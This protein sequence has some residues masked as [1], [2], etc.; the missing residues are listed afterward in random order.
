MRYVEDSRAARLEVAIRS[1]RMPSGQQVDLV[2]VDGRKLRTEGALVTPDG[3]NLAVVAATW[4]AVPA[5]ME[6]TA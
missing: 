4:V 1:F 5:D 3:T 6:V 2:G